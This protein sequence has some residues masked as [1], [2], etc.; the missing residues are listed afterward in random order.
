MLALLFLLAVGTNGWGQIRPG[1]R[2]VWADEFDQPD[3]SRPHAG[4]WTYDLG[5]GGW[6]NNELQTYTARTNN[7]RIENGCLVIEARRE[8]YTGTDGITRQY[9]SARLKTQGRL[10]WRFGRIEARI[11]LP[12]GQG[13][14]PAFWMLGTN[15]PSVGWPAC[16][17]IDIM[18]N[19]GREPGT[20][21]G[22][23]H[24]P[25]Y[26][27][28]DG[29]GGRYVL[30][31]GGA[32]ADDFHVFGVEW[33]PGRIRWFVDNTLYFTVS[34]AS[35]P[36]G[37]SWVFDQPFFLILNVA[38]GGRWPGNPDETTVFPQVMQVDYVRVY[39]REDGGTNG[40]GGNILWNGGFEDPTLAGWVH[41]GNGVS[42]I[43][44]VPGLA[45]AGVHALELAAAEGDAFAEVQVFQEFAVAPGQKFR[46]AG[47]VMNSPVSGLLPGQ[48][49]WLEAV[50]HDGTG[51]VRELHRSAPMEADAPP[52]VWQRL[53][54]T[55][56]LDPVT[57]ALLGSAEELT[58]P[59]GAAGLRVRMAL[60][61]PP[62]GSGA[63][64]WDNLECVTQPAPPVPVEAGLRPETLV[65]R[66]PT[67]AG[68]R[69]AVLGA[70]DLGA[71]PWEV[72]RWHTGDGN[73]AEVVLPRTGDRRFYTVR[74]W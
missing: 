33:E 29:I 25:G 28:G 60:S 54:V 8:T 36:S 50:F 7:C 72:V 56:R 4:W 37:S 66:F 48:R 14:W 63:V 55:N 70:S 13:L 20:V 16:G 49:A 69:Y 64:L 40:C 44:P 3:G 42:A 46:V 71:A 12:R 59:P 57:G 61:R 39:Q 67:C 32:F 52:G 5:G 73:V 53:E 24:G 45:H 43:G 27:G 17:E 47:W 6:G 19:I 9:T 41:A 2:L 22:T 26:S 68:G 58:A 34:P 18:E 31:G 1:W 62:A 30:P 35:L 15:F 11:R 74:R 51:G 23:V 38:V 65:L 21:H 10:A